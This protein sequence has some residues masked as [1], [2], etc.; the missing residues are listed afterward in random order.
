[1]IESKQSGNPEEFSSKIEELIENI[2]SDNN[3]IVMM[4]NSKDFKIAK[5]EVINYISNK[6]GKH[7]NE[8][9]DFFYKD[10]SRNYRLF[11]KEAINELIFRKEVSVDDKGCLQYQF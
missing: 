11:Y 3:N 5:Q 10:I 7:P 8:I 4:K 1:M 2:Y 6:P 9:R